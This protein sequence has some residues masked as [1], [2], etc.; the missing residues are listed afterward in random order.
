MTMELSMFGNLQVYRHGE[1]QDYSMFTGRGLHEA[2]EGVPQAEMLAK[3][4]QLWTT[5]GQGMAITGNALFLTGFWYRILNEKQRN[6]HMLSW[7]A[8]LGGASMTVGGGVLS[9][10]AKRLIYQA[11]NTFNAE[12][13]P[14]FDPQI[15]IHTTQAGGLEGRFMLEW[16]LGRDE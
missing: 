4:Y 6:E 8:V 2:F 14:K 13:D 7:A 16:S 11:V 5:V 3:R 10:S 12:Y 9:Q 15:Q 1:R